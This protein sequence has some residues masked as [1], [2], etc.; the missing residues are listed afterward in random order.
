MKNQ[1]YKF[2]R[3]KASELIINHPE[4]LELDNMFFNKMQEVF[5]F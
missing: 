3:K 5:D 1:M 2:I 4:M